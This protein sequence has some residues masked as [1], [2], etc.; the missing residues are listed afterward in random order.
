MATADLVDV[1]SHLYP[2]VFL[3]LLRARQRYPRVA[4]VD[5]EERFIIFPEED[6]PK[7]PGG[8]PITEPFWS[9]DAKLAFMDE[10]EIGRTVLS[11]GNPWLDPFSPEE[12]LRHAAVLNEAM[13]R[14]G[15]ESDGRLVCLGVLPNASPEDAA[16]TVR[17]LARAE[18]PL[19]GIVTSPR[20]CGSTLDDD[21]LEPLW[22]A[23]DETALPWLLHPSDGLGIREMEG[24]GHALPITFGFPFE[25]S[26]AVARLILA[27]V[28]ERYPRIRLIASHGGGT[29]PFLAARF[30][31]SWH[32]DASARGRLET[33]PT[34]SLA[35]VHAD[36]ITYHPRALLATHDLFE[37]KIAFGTDHPFSVADPRANLAAL[38]VLDEESRRRVLSGLATELFG[39]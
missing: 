33:E 6:D 5:D 24:Y 19:R 12:S 18:H 39:T 38:E 23:L 10:V 3:D 15:S 27:G 14:I 1:H 25:T 36:A 17:D 34:R 22:Q 26:V 32:G 13:G 7:A 8:R 2:P 35:R 16:A 37:G 21:A 28:L 29:L 31:A 4:T 20:V 30:D 9:V 11:L